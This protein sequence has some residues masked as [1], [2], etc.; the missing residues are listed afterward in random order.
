[1]SAGDLVSSSRSL[2]SYV[3][4]ICDHLGISFPHL[5]RRVGL[6][7]D[8]LWKEL[9]L[10]RSARVEVVSLVA[11]ELDVTL[12]ALIFKRVDLAKLLLR[13][14]GATPL[15]ERY[16]V[17]ASGTIRTSLPALNYVRKHKGE[18]LYRYLLRK[19]DLTEKLLRDPDVHVS[20]RLLN[21]IFALLHE[22][23]FEE[24][25]F[26]RMGCELVKVP[27]N[28]RIAKEFAC[29]KSYA[30]VFEFTFENSARLYEK[31]FEYR[32]VKA[33]PSSMVIEVRPWAELVDALKTPVVDTRFTAVYRQGISAFH[34]L[35]S[36]MRPAS[37]H[38]HGCV[39]LGDD[40]MRYELRWA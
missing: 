15:P 25:D 6:S 1:M 20:I 39:H 33:K 10:D 31:N 12:D 5:A 38:E 26:F 19:L 29:M 2:G 37:I 40:A 27:E 34:P 14:Q 36:G 11:E 22:R 7:P 9:R 35:F 17:G 28:N 8:V 16:K 30:K 32:I 13:Y 18:R 4:D 21:D 3:V 23:G 24:S